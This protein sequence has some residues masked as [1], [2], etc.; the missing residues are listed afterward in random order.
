M[1]KI[2]IQTK[3]IFKIPNLLT[4]FRIFV[5]LAIYFL[6]LSKFYQEAVK[7]LFLIGVASDALDGIF[8]RRLNQI[9]RLGIILEPVADTLLVFSAVLF[10]TFRL[11]LHPYIFVIYLAIFFV[12]FLNLLAI[13]FSSGRWFAKK[14]EISEVSI[15]FVYGT[16]IFYLF[17]LP[18]KFYLAT[19]SI[20]IGVFALFDFLSQLYRFKRSL[21]T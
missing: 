10:I 16:G 6:F 18:Y 20:I 21:K 9:S 3:D 7:W 4:I 8:A 15:F 13:Y 19:L 14:L 12:G 2:K 17:N 11:D 1:G 5:A